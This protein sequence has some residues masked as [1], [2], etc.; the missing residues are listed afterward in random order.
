MKKLIYI[1]ELRHYYEHDGEMFGIDF[2]EEHGVEVEVWSAVYW[3]FGNQISAP[4][5]IKKGKDLIYINSKEAMRNRLARISDKD[6][7]FIV[8]PYNAYSVVSYTIRRE[9]KKAGFDFCNLTEVPDLIEMDPKP[10]TVMRAVQF[11]IKSVWNLGKYYILRVLGRVE[12]KREG[13]RLLVSFW[14]PIFWKSKYNLI[15]SRSDLATLSN[16]FEIFSKR[17]IIFPHNHCFD[18]EKIKGEKRDRNIIV[19]VDEYE[20]GHSDWEKLGYPMPIQ[21]QELY[22]KELNHFFSLLEEKF[23][24]IVVIAAHPKA[25]YVNNEF[26][27]REICYYKTK[28]LIRDARLVLFMY[29]TSLSYI[30]LFDKPFILFCTSEAMKGGHKADEFRI[31]VAQLYG[32]DIL[33]IG[34]D[35][36][37]GG[38]E[39]KI[40]NASSRNKEISEFLGANMDCSKNVFQFI[41]ELLHS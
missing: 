19:F 23:N 25:E 30:A 8:Y 14:G 2:F 9:I 27:G 39:E 41:L 15:I 28:E 13:R 21:N 37:G 40:I 7:L 32:A 34:L 6:C 38:L 35:Y 22:Y 17:N 31:K 5:N 33:Q 12:K 18:A 10:Y 24:S 36:N 3:T 11:H 16:K 4:V 29:G 1:F 26:D 20:C